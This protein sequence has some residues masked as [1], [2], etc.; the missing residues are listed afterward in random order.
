MGAGVFTTALLVLLAFWVLSS[1]RDVYVSSSASSLGEEEECRNGEC[2]AEEFLHLIPPLRDIAGDEN[3]R[4]ALEKVSRKL[5]QGYSLT[6]PN[7]LHTQAAIALDGADKGDLALRAFQAQ[8]HFNLAADANDR[9]VAD[10]FGNLAVALLRIGRYDDSHDALKIAHAKDPANQN[11]IENFGVLQHYLGKDVVK[12]PGTLPSSREQG[13]SNERRHRDYLIYQRDVALAEKDIPRIDVDELYL[14]GNEK[15]A[16]LEAPF[17]LTGAMKGWDAMQKSGWWDGTYLAEKWP[18]TVCDYY[19]YNML[20]SSSPYLWRL[21][22]VLSEFDSPRRHRDRAALPGRYLHVQLT[23][24][25]WKF[26]ETKS[27][28]QKDRAPVLQNDW[29]LWSCLKR[30]SLVDEFHIKT[31]WKIM[32][33][34]SAGAGMHNH[35]D[36]LLTSSWHAHLKGEKWWHLCS[37]DPQQG[38]MESVIK[39]GEILYYGVGWHHETQNLETPTTTYTDTIVTPGNY[40]GI[41]GKLLQS[42]ARGDPMRDFSAELC[43]VLDTCYPMWEGKWGDGQK[44]EWPTW[45]SFADH[46]Q[47]A[48]REAIE[49]HHNNYDGRNYISE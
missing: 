43:D 42:C 46:S 23:S 25:M 20:E 39:A 13:K 24:D 28:V 41:A 4:A 21:Y 37:P 17:I 6:D 3:V 40:R 31:H 1:E 14:D 36:S 16:R 32:L 7:G 27:A 18:Q 34:G 12:V 11:V 29:W 5:P 47:L 8:I 19:P 30:K 35:S 9:V 2:R 49:S 15:Y 44:S 48:E 45:R 38:C 10:A 22:S 26:L 33:M